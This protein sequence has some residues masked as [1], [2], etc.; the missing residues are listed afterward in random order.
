M[1]SVQGELKL[2]REFHARPMPS[3]KAAIIHV[4][5]KLPVLPVAPLQVKPLFTPRQTQRN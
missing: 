4:P 5:T 3:S 1:K 2:T